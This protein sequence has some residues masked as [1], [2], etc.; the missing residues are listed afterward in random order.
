MAHGQLLIASHLDFL[1]KF[2]KP[3]P[4]ADTLAES[5]EY[6]G[7]DATVR[8]FGMTKHCASE[9]SRV[10]QV[11]RPTYELIRQGKMPESESILGRR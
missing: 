6:K 5:P 11:V 9:F 2:L 1:L 7:L 8:K 10:D 4:K 3:I